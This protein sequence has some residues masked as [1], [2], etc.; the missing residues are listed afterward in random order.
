MTPS[1]A[2]TLA[3]IVNGPDYLLP[4]RVSPAQCEVLYL[5]ARAAGAR[6]T[7][8]VGNGAPAA[9]AFHQYENARRAMLAANAYREA[10]AAA[11]DAARELLACAAVADAAY[12]DGALAG[13]DAARVAA[14]ARRN[15]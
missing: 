9:D 8:A 5:A 7:E 3:E 12:Y 6:F 2:R 10:I 4:F 14:V 13:M 1:T 11:S 15:G